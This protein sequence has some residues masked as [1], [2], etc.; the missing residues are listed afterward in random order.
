MRLTVSERERDRERD[1]ERLREGDKDTWETWRTW[2][3]CIDHYLLLNRVVPYTHLYLELILN[4]TAPYCYSG[5]YW[6]LLHLLWR[7]VPHRS[8][9]EASCPLTAT[10]GLKDSKL[11]TEQSTKDCWVLSYRRAPPSATKRISSVPVYI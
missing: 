4:H 8:S 5:P 10:L 9:P 3:Y 2:T 7:D 11:Q 1:R 6:A